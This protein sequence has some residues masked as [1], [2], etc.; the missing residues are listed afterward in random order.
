MH[1][2]TVTAYSKFKF[3]INYSYLLLASLVKATLDQPPPI[4]DPPHNPNFLLIDR[5]FRN[6]GILFSK[7]FNFAL[8]KHPRNKG[9]LM[10]SREYVDNLVAW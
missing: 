4:Y 7:F 9:Y 8:K 6:G 1:K 2:H 5:H 10:T 3:L